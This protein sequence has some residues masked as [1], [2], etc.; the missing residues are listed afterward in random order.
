MWMLVGRILQ[1]D[2]TTTGEALG[3][4]NDWRVLEIGG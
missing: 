4:E 1:V 2:R 3:E